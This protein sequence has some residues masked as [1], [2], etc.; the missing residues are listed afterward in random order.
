MRE[1]YIILTWVF[2]LKFSFLQ[3]KRWGGGSRKEKYRRQMS[4]IPGFRS[5]GTREMRT[6]LLLLE[7]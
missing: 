7:Q 6:K 5:E 4:Q 3:K 2:F 1:L